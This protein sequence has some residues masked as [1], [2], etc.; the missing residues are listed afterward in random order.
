M[1]NSFKEKE[2]EEHGDV[3]LPSGTID[4]LIDILSEADKFSL[5]RLTEGW[6][7]LL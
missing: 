3:M 4:I 5:V 1:Y 6:E 7:Q 2:E